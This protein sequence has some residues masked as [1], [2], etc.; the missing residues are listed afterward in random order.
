M[1]EGVDPETE[2]T[3]PREPVAGDDEPASPERRRGLM[4]A[5]W[6]A[7]LVLVVFAAGVA[8][9]PVIVP[10]LGG[11]GPAAITVLDSDDLDARLGGLGE[12]L[13]A[14]ENG[15]ADTEDSRAAA[16]RRLDGLERRGAAAEGTANQIAARLDTALAQ[17]RALERRIG[18]LE[19]AGT[20]LEDAGTALDLLAERLAALE[21][22]LAEA[23]A[24]AKE[25]PGRGAVVALERRLDRIEASVASGEGSASA[26]LAESGALGER[27]DALEARLKGALDVGQAVDA[28]GE[29]AARLGDR[30]RIET[31]RIAALEAVAAAG[32]PG[33]VDLVLAISRL[34]QALSGS[35]PFAEDLALVERLGAGEAAFGGP[36]EVLAAHAEVGVP[37]RSVLRA[38]FPT[39]A[40]EAIQAD[41][42]AEAGDWLDKT[43]ARLGRL[44]SVRRTGEVAGAGTGAVVARAEARLGTGDL[45]AAVAELGG[46]EGAAAEAAADWLAEAAARLASERALDDLA[47]AAAAGEG[48]QAR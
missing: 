15:A 29:D 40:R 44:V 37:A 21:T 27:L 31:A 24:L 48:G 41:R 35:G 4:R 36:L 18:A 26:P 25:D 28:L 11:E 14:L 6:L 33:R 8:L 46:L 19:D 2:E 10:W 38:R 39:L 1:S 30:L 47:A 9:W 45:G 23:A 5:V 13:D 3:P 22:G 17:A 7:V 32:D 20:A 16:L 42:D 34:R 12:R 43:V